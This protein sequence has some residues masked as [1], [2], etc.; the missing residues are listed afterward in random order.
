MFCDWVVNV[1]SVAEEEKAEVFADTCT[2]VSASG[3]NLQM[4]KWEQLLLKIRCGHVKPR[5]T[6]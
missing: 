3:V 5:Q 2:D 1:K 6:F 4:Q